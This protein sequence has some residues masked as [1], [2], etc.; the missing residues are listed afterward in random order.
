MRSR[1]TKKSADRAFVAAYIVWFACVLAGGFIG[2]S[3]CK[4]DPWGFLYMLSGGC[5]GSIIGG[6][7][8][9]GVSL[10]ITLTSKER[11]E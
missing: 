10:A 7:I 11:A 4:S 9:L 2:M 1:P 3:W 6:V 5:I 8:S